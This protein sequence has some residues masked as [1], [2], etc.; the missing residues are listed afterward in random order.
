MRNHQQDFNTIPPRRPRRLAWL[1][2]ALSLV[3]IMVAYLALSGGGAAAKGQVQFQPAADVGP[4]PFTAP[5][6]ASAGQAG[7]GIGAG[8]FGGT[9]SN[10][11]CDRELLIRSLIA[12]PERLRAWANAVGIEPTPEAVTRYIRTLHS[13]RLSQDTPITN[14]TFENGEAV[15][16]QSV[17]EAGTA[18]LVDDKGKL[19]ARCRCGNPLKPALYPPHKYEHPVCPGCKTHRPHCR[20]RP[21]TDTTD[22]P[23][24]YRLQIAGGQGGSESTVPYCPPKCPQGATVQDGHCVTIGTA[25][26][27]GVPGVPSCDSHGEKDTSGEPCPPDQASSSDEQQR[28]ATDDKAAAKVDLDCLKVDPGSL[29]VPHRVV[30][31]PRFHEDT[32]YTGARLGQD[33]YQGVDPARLR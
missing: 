23:H 25:C 31:D 19:I 6:D 1:L 26:A 22:P 20:P 3:A 7:Q 13:I 11:V 15:G 5:L 27:K 18:V 29:K 16:F 14:H 4:H 32:R 8:P 10:A 28:T 17:L 12:R 33:Q 24:Y 30:P 2:P 9:G 21:S